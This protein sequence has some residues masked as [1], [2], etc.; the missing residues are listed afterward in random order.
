MTEGRDM[1]GAG[2]VPGEGGVPE[3]GSNEPVPGSAGEAAAADQALS[4]DQAPAA[5]EAPAEPP[6]IGWATGVQW[7]PVAPPSQA[8][9][10]PAGIKLDVGS[11]LGRTF[12][13][14][15][16]R[17]MLFLI[18]AAPGAIFSAV[19]AA[20]ASNPATTSAGI[21]LLGSLVGI[22]INVIF[23]LAMI[24]ATDDVRA[25]REPSFDSATG[26]AMGRFGAAILSALAEGLAFVGLFVVPLVIASVILVGSRGGA[27]A[28][29]GGL[30]L[31]ATVVGL[32]AIAVRWLLA[33]P[34]IV[35]DGFGPIKG[36]N[37]SRAVTKGNTWRLFGV[38]V[39]LGL[40][41]LPLSIGLTALSLG[42]GPSPIE[43]A[44]LAVTTLIS[45][46]LS[47]IATAT[48]YG[49]LTGRP[50]VEPPAASTRQVRNILIA[51]ILA[52]GVVALVVGIPQIGP[53]LSRLGLSQVPAELRGQILA[54]TSR[55]P[56]DPCRPVGVRSTF[57][58]TDPIYVGGYFTKVVPA[59]E[60]ATVSSYVNG[61]LSNTSSLSSPT[62]AVECY[63]EP[64]SVTGIPPGTYRLVVTYAGETIGEGT[65]TIQ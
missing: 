65:F 17:W 16:R 56:L 25:G 8:V 34:A 36:L 43:I 15:I 48:A 44:L 57:A 47:A 5:D 37:R 58:T 10:E 20:V 46:P 33:Q 49:D 54:G 55:N 26:R 28:V 61:A 12:D 3:P 60:T 9:L 6:T 22:A 35:L 31:V 24:V 32:I 21:S 59:G 30:I 41:F 11:V 7:E 53:G 4:A 27:G 29:V 18:L 23:S 40:V 52:V 19:V 14:F 64:D 42:E 51:I 39:V 13:T 50:A 45:G 38:F 1:P 2:G 62:Q 63:Y